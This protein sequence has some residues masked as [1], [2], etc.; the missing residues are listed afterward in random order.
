[1]KANLTKFCAV[2]LLAAQAIAVGQKTEVS[3]QKGKLSMPDG[4]PCLQRIKSQQ[5]P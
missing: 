5:S 1:M 4:R 3:V 2:V